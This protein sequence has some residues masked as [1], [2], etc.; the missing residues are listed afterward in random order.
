MGTKKVKYVE[1]WLCR[2]KKKDRGSVAFFETA[3]VLLQYHTAW[4]WALRAPDQGTCRQV[5]TADEFDRIYGLKKAPGYG[6]KV[7]ADMEL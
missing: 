5:W 1:G 6:K 3:S 2:D 4:G 7:L